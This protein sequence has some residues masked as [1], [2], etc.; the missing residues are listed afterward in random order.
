MSYTEEQ[1]TKKNIGQIAELQ[2]SKI[3]ADFSGKSNKNSVKI[4]DNVIAFI[5]AAG[6]TGTSTVVANLAYSIAKKG[7]TVLV[8]DLNIQYPVQHC[9]LGFKQEI[10]KK[11]LV[12]FLLGKNHLGESIETKDNMSLMFA[13]NRYLMDQINCDTPVCAKNLTETLDRVRP[14]FDI[15]IIDCPR[16]MEFDIVN[17]VLYSCDT[18]YSVWDEG[19][20]CIANIDRMRKNM[21]VSGIEAYSKMKVVFNKKTNIHYT[22]YVFDQLGL[23]VVETLPFDTALIESGL[24]GEVFCEKGASM[25]RNAAAFSNSMGSLA[26]KV[27][28][29]GGYKK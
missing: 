22:K 29:I 20:S 5:G 12:S 16:S 6:G 15:I 9:L 8:V 18:I 7:M 1:S 27:L 17:S 4:I 2:A 26:D 11:D 24:K 19:I 28:E 3:I 14:M 23:K 10:E 21:Q 25:S 13:N